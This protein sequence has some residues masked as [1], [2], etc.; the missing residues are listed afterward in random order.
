MPDLFRHPRFGKIRRMRERQPCVYILASAF[1]GT[2]Y[3]GVTSDL[4][5]RLYQDREGITGGFTKRYSVKR[6]VYFEMA[7][8]MEGAITREKLLK[9]WPREWKRNLIERKN[10]AWNDLALGLGFEPLS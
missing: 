1:N 4:I 5:A 8:T 10:P 2:L 9:K 6:L 3:F 7:D